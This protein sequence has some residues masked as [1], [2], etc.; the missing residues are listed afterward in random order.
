MQDS[1]LAQILLKVEHVKKP[2]PAHR[3]KVF[4]FMKPQ[5]VLVAPPSRLI[6]GGGIQ[7]RHVAGPPT[8]QPTQRTSFREAFARIEP[9]ESSLSDRVRVQKGDTLL[10]LTRQYLQSKGQTTSAP[11]V[12]RTAMSIAKHNGLANPDLILAGQVLD[13]S[14]VGATAVPERRSAPSAALSANTP[15]P[16]GPARAPIAPG[17]AV[18]SE[19]QGKIA[20]I[21][22]S[23]A[24]GIGGALLERSG[25]KPEFAPGRKFLTQSHNSYVVD[26]TGG[27]S[28]PQILD[29]LRKNPAVR[30]ADVAIISVGT[31]DLVNSTVNK[32]YTPERITQNLQR[33]RGE[34]GAKER[35]WVL[36]YDPQARELVEAVARENG[37]KT[38]DLAQ[39]RP[40][41][42]YHP[43]NYSAIAGTIAPF[44]SS[45]G[46]GVTDP[47]GFDRTRYLDQKQ[48]WLSTQDA[49]RTK[50][51]QHL[52][53]SDSAQ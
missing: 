32:Y 7:V 26:A 28:S 45:S 17:P 47:T 24:V 25:I 49:L 38:V 14:S 4:I 1:G 48:A 9:S 53:G 33:I 15:S 35:I 46:S 10:G 44:L 51:G 41:D 34:L 30:H 27:H 43:R 18:V 22:D 5:G 20:V 52:S 12:Y 37:D 3:L 6:D 29:R 11:D 42:R 40:A 31:N 2:M 16:P 36:P 39:F 19:G 13:F 23:I 21:G 8:L 50:G